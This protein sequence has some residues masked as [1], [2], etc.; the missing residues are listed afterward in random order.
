MPILPLGVII[1]IWLDRNS[2][3]F[4]RY[5][6]IAIASLLG[7]QIGL[8]FAT[9]KLHLQVEPLTVAHQA[10]GAALLGTVVILIVNLLRQGDRIIAD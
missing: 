1:T 2:P 10:I 7:L 9:F 5:L 3:T 6:A 8:G 4:Y